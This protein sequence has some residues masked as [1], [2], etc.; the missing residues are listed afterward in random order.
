MFWVLKRKRKEVIPQMNLKSA[1]CKYFMY[2]FIRQDTKTLQVSFLW[3]I[4]MFYTL[5]LHLEFHGSR[6]YAATAFVES[7]GPVEI[8]EHSFL[9]EMSCSQSN[10]MAK[11]SIV[12]YLQRDMQNC[13]CL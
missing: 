6:I 10:V 8:S 3:L 2:R 5:I 11:S 4:V 9:P 13:P 1:A 12:P 7:I